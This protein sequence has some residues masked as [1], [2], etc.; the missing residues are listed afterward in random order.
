M[1]KRRD[2][3]SF[4]KS[5]RNAGCLSA[6]VVLLVVVGVI[7]LL[8]FIAHDPSG[9]ASGINY[10]WGRLGDGARA[11]LHAPIDFFNALLTFVEQVGG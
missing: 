1:S 9:A 5:M 7:V 3:K 4:R 8:A 2:R 10:W 11:I 6:L